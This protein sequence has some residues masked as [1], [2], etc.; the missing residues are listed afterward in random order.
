MERL[1]QLTNREQEILSFIKEGNTSLDIAEQLNITKN[2][3]DT[4][5]RN[6]LKKTNSKSVFLLI[7]SLNK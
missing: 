6:I 3:V 5:R 4:H 2:T 7:N 1:P